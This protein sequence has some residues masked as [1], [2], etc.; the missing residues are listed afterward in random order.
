MYDENSSPQESPKA[1][2][3]FI[4][5]QPPTL[6]PQIKMNNSLPNGHQSL[7]EVAEEDDQ[8]ERQDGEHD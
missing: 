3:S 7:H 5:Q 2:G 6:P 4:R 1:S 8:Q